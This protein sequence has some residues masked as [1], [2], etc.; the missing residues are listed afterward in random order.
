[1]VGFSL[2]HGAGAVLFFAPLVLAVWTVIVVVFIIVT[3]AKG[4]AVGVLTWSSFALAL[5]LFG[6]LMMPAGV[7]QRVFVERMAS[8]SRAGD[9][10]VYAAY[11]HDVRTVRALLDHGVSITATDRGPRRTV[12]H[13]AAAAGDLAI[14]REV[15][16]RGA[17][18]NALDRAGDS[19]LEL[20]LANNHAD[21]ARFL[22]ERGAKRIRGDDAQRQ[23][24]IEE[25]VRETSGSN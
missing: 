19:P 5:L 25:Q 22:E 3:I 14:L 20:A 12:V 9:L 13:A 10:L 18:V 23:K 4:R 17:E 16:S 11:G 21:C 15:I 8:S 1:M 2:A 7:W 6:L 24:A